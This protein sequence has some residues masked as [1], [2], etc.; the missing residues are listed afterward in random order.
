MI[1]YQRVSV[2]YLCSHLFP[3]L[4]SLQGT[5]SRDLMVVTWRR[6]GDPWIRSDVLVKTMGKPWEPW[7]NHGKT[8]GF[9]NITNITN[10][11]KPIK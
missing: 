4:P 10:Q 5:F 8:M 2:I 7:E 11:Y 1:N 3:L 9:C 6:T